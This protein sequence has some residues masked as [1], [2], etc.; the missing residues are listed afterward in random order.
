M[1]TKE[2][3]ER[4]RNPSPITERRQ[5]LGDYKRVNSRQ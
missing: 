3:L 4:R 2:D 5:P 1:K